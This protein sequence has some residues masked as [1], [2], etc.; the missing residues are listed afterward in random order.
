MTELYSYILKTKCITTSKSTSF[1]VL[2]LLS[3]IRL[4]HV[5]LDFA[6]YMEDFVYL[7]YT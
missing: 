2:K 6:T 5:K 3:E 1:L 4:L 7:K